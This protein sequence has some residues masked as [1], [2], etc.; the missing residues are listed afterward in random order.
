MYQSANREQ[1]LI[2][3]DESVVDKAQYSYYLIPFDYYGNDAKSTDTVN[4]YN[5]NAGMIPSLV[6]RFRRI[7]R[8]KGKDIRLSWQLD[9]TEDIV[10]IDIYKALVYDGY[11]THI[12]S[13]APGDTDFIDRNVLPVTSYYYSLVLNTAYGRTYPS[14]RIPVI[15]K[16]GK[17]NDFPPA[18]LKAIREGNTV[19]LSWEQAGKDIRGYYLY[20]SGSFTGQM[21]VVTGIIVNSDS[22][23]RYVDTLAQVTDS[24]VLIYAVAS[25]NSSENISPLSSRVS[26]TNM[27][28]RMPIPTG[29]QGCC[30]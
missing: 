30:R 27:P 17:S 12:A 25:V 28:D 2:I 15:N 24:P 3:A 23:V 22:I 16:A 10:S 19:S 18:N 6:T 11:Y 9:N 8:E 4:V 7:S 29:P 21:Q 13:V 20:R 26:V 1:H 14:V 5:G